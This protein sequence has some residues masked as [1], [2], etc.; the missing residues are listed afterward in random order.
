MGRGPWDPLS[1]GQVAC[2]PAPAGL[3]SLTEPAC[4][5]I[6]IGTTHNRECA[7]FRISLSLSIANHHECWPSGGGAVRCGMG[8]PPAQVIPNPPPGAAWHAWATRLRGQRTGTFPGRW[9]QL[10]H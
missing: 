4:R 1:P 8:P 10:T 2:D 9:K 6:G 5:Y 7:L 3:P